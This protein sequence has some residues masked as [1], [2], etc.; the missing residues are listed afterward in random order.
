[1]DLKKDFNIR[2]EPRKKNSQF[3]LFAEMQEDHFAIRDKDGIPR[4]GAEI[5]ERWL[6]P[7]KYF[8]K[9]DVLYYDNFKT[10]ESDINFIIECL[11]DRPLTI[12]FHEIND[13]N[14]WEENTKKFE[15]DIKN[16]LL[17]LNHPDYV[18]KYDLIYRSI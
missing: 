6:N 17:L 5:V 2:Y 14:E 12:I 18:F 10:M 13:L 1:M 4:F 7:N 16:P 3:I 15:L 11:G 9:Y 8:E